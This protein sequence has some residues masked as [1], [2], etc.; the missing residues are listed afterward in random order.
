MPFLQLREVAMEYYNCKNNDSSQW[1]KELIKLQQIQRLLYQQRNYDKYC[2]N[3]KIRKP[4]QKRRSYKKE[5]V[6]N[7]NKYPWYNTTQTSRKT[8]AFNSLL[9]QG[10]AISK[11]L[12][13]A[14]DESEILSSLAMLQ[15]CDSKVMPAEKEFYDI[16]EQCEKYEESLTPEKEIENDYTK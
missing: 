3:V 11:V 16:Y 13:S 10:L 8:G 12:E 2:E 1:I 9:R 5:V 4:V 15:Q 7:N 14:D 6:S